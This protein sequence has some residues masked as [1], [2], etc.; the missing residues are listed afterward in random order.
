MAVVAGVR[1]FGQL[2]L[3]EGWS[4]VEERDPVVCVIGAGPAGL[5]VAHLLLRAGISFVVLERQDADGL[6]ARVKAGQI[7]DRTVEL[8]RPH[9]LADTILER[10]TR[11]G[12]C[13]FRADGEAFVLDYGE[14]CRGRCHYIYPQHELVSDWAE[15]LLDAGGDVRFGVRVVS[16]EQD[17]HGASVEAVFTATGTPLHIRAEVVACCDGAAGTFSATAGVT[18]VDMQHPFRWLTVIA[19]APASKQRYIYGMHPRGFAAQARRSDTLTRYMLEV[20]AAGGLGDWPDERIWA[21]LQQRLAGTGQPPLEQGEFVER[22]VLD[23]RVRVREPMQ[24][25]RVFFAGDAAH[26]ITP[27]GGKGMNLAVHDAFEL[28]AGL[29]ERYGKTND[30]Q[31]LAAYSQTRL[32]IVWRYQEFSNFMLGLLHAGAALNQQ[33]AKTLDGPTGET[34]FA[35]R[36]RRARLDRVINDPQFS[37]WFAHAYAGVDE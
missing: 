35:Y 36:I 12:V 14:L 19:A 8:L 24:F 15:A 1:R 29:D 25:G 32:P 4:L 10:G 7:E 20:P 5:V 17:E 21:E 22:D 16:V 11:N 18:S 31:R 26:L 37:R 23:P 27:A 13:E 33:P 28:A 2:T 3:P 6:R 9:G 34:S 30:G